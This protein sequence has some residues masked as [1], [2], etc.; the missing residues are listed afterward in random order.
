[1]LPFEYSAMSSEA[2]GSSY[3]DAHIG[4]A[5]WY[6]NVSARSGVKQVQTEVCSTSAE[7]RHPGF[8]LTGELRRWV[9]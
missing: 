5:G 6:A 9:E 4:L 1:M 2:D 3:L 8:I 7:A